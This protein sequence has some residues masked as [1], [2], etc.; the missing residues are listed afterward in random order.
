MA[1]IL[2]FIFIFCNASFLLFF[3]GPHVW[4][5][6]IPGL[7]VE[8]ELPLLIYTTAIATRDPSIC[9]LCHSLLWCQILNP[10]S[11]ARD[12]THIL[13]DIMSGS[14]FFFFFNFPTVQQYVRFLTCWA[15]M[16]ILAMVVLNANIRAF[17]SYVESP[18]SHNWYF[19][20]HVCIYTSFL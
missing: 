6:E 1:W 15:T 20:A 5:M 18:K 12:W 17:I 11:E 9:N 2:P 16:G 7:G 10:L 13:T 19:I 3:L 4:H 8:L 14:F